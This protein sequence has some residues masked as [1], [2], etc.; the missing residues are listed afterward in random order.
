M[1][2]LLPPLA[3]RVRSDSLNRAGKSHC[4]WSHPDEREKRYGYGKNGILSIWK[5]NSKTQNTWQT[6]YLCVLIVRVLGNIDAFLIRTNNRMFQLVLPG[7]VI[8]WIVRQIMMVGRIACSQQKD[9][10][11]ESAFFSGTFTHVTL[12]RTM[13]MCALHVIVLI[14]QFVLFFTLLLSGL[15]L[16]ELC[17]QQSKVWC[18]SM[19]SWL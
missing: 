7:P 14:L 15:V 16:G 12:N 9:K 10:L 3:C 2:A 19:S 5:L 8:L 17:A 18:R 4:G 13:L 11:L 6:T 1:R